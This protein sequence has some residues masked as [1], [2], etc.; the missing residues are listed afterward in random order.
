M[1]DLPTPITHTP[2]IPIDPK[3]AKSLGKQILPCIVCGD[4]TLEDP[5]S[6]FARCWQCLQPKERRAP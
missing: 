1:N 5:G 4:P 3:H 6:G 2:V